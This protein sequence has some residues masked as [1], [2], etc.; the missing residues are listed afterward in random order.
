MQDIDSSIVFGRFRMDLTRRTLLA[1]GQPVALHARAFDILEYLVA[2][3][4]RAVTRDEIIGHVWRGLVVGENNLSVQMSTLRRV[5]SQHGGGDL[6]VT[7]PHRGYQ[8]IETAP[9]AASI[10]AAMLPTAQ[11]PPL[12]ETAVTS[13][14]DQTWRSLAW[15][16]PVAGCALLVFLLIAT[17]LAGRREAPVPGPQAGTAAPPFNPPPHSVA[18]LAFTNLSGEPSQDYLS[19]GLSE[20]LIESLSQIRQVQV[21]ARTSSFFFK[22]KAATIKDIAL[23]LDVAA[24]VEGSVRRQGN[25]LRIEVRLTDARTGFEL[26]SRPFD[27]D[28]GDMLKVEADIAAQ[29]ADGLQVK[30]A[31]GR[32]PD[33]STGGTAN[34][35]A[36]DAFLHGVQSIRHETIQSYRD[37]L[38]S[39]QAAIDADHDFALAYAGKADA[40]VLI[41]NDE[42]VPDP[43]T[44]GWM[45]SASLSAAERSVQLAPGNG[46]THAALSNI[47][48]NSLYLRRAWVEAEQ[49]QLLDPGNSTVNL[50]F[51]GVAISEGRIDRAMQAARRVVELDPLREDGWVNLGQ[52]FR[53]ARDFDSAFKAY[54]H[55]QTVAGTET[56]LI[57]YERALAYITMGNPERALDISLSGSDWMHLEC[58]AIAQHAL[59]RQHDAEQTFAELVRKD[60]NNFNYVYAEIYA[61]WGKT[62][63]ALGWLAKAKKL[64]DSGLAN[65]KID[66]MM[67][68]IRNEPGFKAIEA[69]LS[70]PD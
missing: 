64:H 39:F 34:A 4:D 18:V 19:D 1:D 22:G 7:V 52:Q 27:S 53:I 23:A 14:Q 9:A 47:L 33:G 10:A 38:A 24:V 49:A 20:E 54:Q 66:P 55:A 6:I 63:E 42:D 29:V 15:R 5:L 28:L 56:P 67:D 31:A 12:G 43:A 13:G 44:D 57:A 36:L 25:H 58:R 59:G 60:G 68:P 2:S 11:E 21:T 41:A 45:Y 51:S 3:R 70:F 65:I 48:A 8:F 30:L 40:L 37:A 32:A 46:L 16:W 17:I 62:V 69:R 50:I 26:W 35:R 61:Q